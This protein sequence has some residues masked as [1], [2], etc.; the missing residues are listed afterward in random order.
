LEL[1]ATIAAAPETIIVAA[2][3]KPIEFFFFNIIPS[4]CSLDFAQEQVR[5]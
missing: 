3:A 1:F 2:R 4:F 5:K